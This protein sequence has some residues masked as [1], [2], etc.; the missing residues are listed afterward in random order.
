M[1]IEWLLTISVIIISLLTSFIL[2]RVS[3]PGHAKDVDVAPKADDKNK[4]LDMVYKLQPDIV[5]TSDLNFF[6]DN[7]PEDLQKEIPIAYNLSFSWPPNKG[8][9]AKLT[10]F[11][12]PKGGGQ[13]WLSNFITGMASLLDNTANSITF[14]GWLVSIY[15]PKDPNNNAYGKWL[16]KQLPWKDPSKTPKLGQQKI[17]VE[18]T[19]ACYP[20]PNYKYPTCDDGGYWLYMTPGSGVF[21]S[22]TGRLNNEASNGCLVANNK[23]DAMFLMLN[24]QQGKQYLEEKAGKENTPLEFLTSQLQGTGGGLS[25]IKAMQKV[26]DAMQNNIQVPTI[27]AFRDMRKSNSFGTWYA[28]ITYTTF[29]VITIVALLVYIGLS[30]S[31]SFRGKRSGWLTLGIFILSLVFVFGLLLLWYFVVSDNMLTGFGYI[32]LD[33]AL[34][35]S[36]LSL[37][38]FITASRSGKNMLANSL[39]MI[40]NFDFHLEALASALNLDSIIFHT[41]PNKSGSWAVEII[42][43]RN[44]PFIKNGKPAKDAKDLI[45][46]L[47]LCGQPIPGPGSLPDKMPGLMQGP[48]IS[49]PG[50]YLGFQPTR[51]CNCDEESVSDAYKKTGDLKKCVYCSK[52][53]D[54][55]PLSNQLC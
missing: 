33:M 24:T 1:R 53:G 7:L 51:A 32:T 26:I 14:P 46:E 28:W 30:V 11:P 49:S 22:P 44:T 4:Y 43:V 17:W 2:Y 45:Y 6:W 40:Q 13:G 8:E 27:T 9:R 5:N 31:K 25:L 16:N 52:Q 54:W 20:P 48:V 50:V 18:V 23:I 55:V 19:H 47:G 29:V 39:A 35:E 37:P 42:D 21:W 38:D 10:A 15:D 36:K 12:Y 3:L 41:Q 34:K